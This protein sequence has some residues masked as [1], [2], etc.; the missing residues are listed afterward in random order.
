MIHNRRNHL[1]VTTSMLIAALLFS[2]ACHKEDNN[3][4]ENKE[5]VISVSAGIRDDTSADK[6]RVLTITAGM[7]GDYRDVRIAPPTIEN[8]GSNAIINEYPRS[9]VSHQWEAGVNVH[10]VFVQGTNQK[11]ALVTIQE[12]GISADAKN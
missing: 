11:Q 10:L 6:D 8:L 3:F 12:S 5:R 2:T 1:F 7:P 4:N 9:G